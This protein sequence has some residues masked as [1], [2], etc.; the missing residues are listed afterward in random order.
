MNKGNTLEAN[1]LSKIVVHRKAYTRKN[2]VKVSASTF[3]IKDRGAS[4]RT[5]KSKRW[6]EFNT[7]TGWKKTQRPSTRYAKMLSATDKRTSLHD[8]YVEAGRMLNQLANVTVD[9]PTERTARDDADY[10]FKKARESQ[11][12]KKISK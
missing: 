2:G 11:N 10:F 5:P 8:R 7:K 4:G 3:K 12:D 1:M 9:Q 6:A